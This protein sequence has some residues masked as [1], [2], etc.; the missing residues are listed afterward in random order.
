MPA[1]F[2]FLTGGNAQIPLPAKKRLTHD[3]WGVSSLYV[4]ISTSELFVRSFRVSDT[5]RPAI[6]RT[7]VK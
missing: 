2:L 7:V 4:Y 1:F 6:T 5:I 3:A